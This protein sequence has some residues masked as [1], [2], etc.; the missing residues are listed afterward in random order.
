MKTVPTP[1]DQPGGVSRR[2]AVKIGAVGLT[3][4]AAGAGLSA[5]ATHLP[6]KKRGPWRFFTETEATLAIE[7]CEQIIPRDDTAGATDAGVIV[8]LDRQLGGKLA[9]H[10]KHCRAGLEALRQSCLAHAGEPFEKLATEKKIA[11]MQLVEAGK[12]PGKDW[13]RADQ[14]AFFRLMVD[15]TMQGFYG[16]ARHGGNRDYISYKIIGIDYPQVIGRNRHG[17]KLS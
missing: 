11:F 2:T 8:Y 1:P 13:A 16:S 7:L 5:L 12:A 4:L 3:G 6:Q 17:R 15:L 9:K 10:A 14:T